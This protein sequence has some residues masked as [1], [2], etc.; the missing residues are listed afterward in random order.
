MLVSFPVPQAVL[1][2]AQAV[3]AAGGQAICVGGSVRDFF[4][5]IPPK[6]FD[7]ECHRLPVQHLLQVLASLNPERLDVVGVSFGVVKITLHGLELD[8]SV[9]RKDNK[10]GQGHTGFQVETDPGMGF[11]AACQRRDLTINAIGI[12]PLTGEVLDPCKGLVHLEQ[13]LLCMVNPQTF[14]E[15]PLRALRVMQLVARLG[16]GVEVRTRIAIEQMELSGLPAERLQEEIKKL[17]L[18]GKSFVL[19]AQLEASSKILQRSC[20]ITRFALQGHRLSQLKNQCQTQGCSETEMLVVMLAELMVGSPELLDTLKIHSLNGSN[21][22]GMIQ[23]LVQNRFCAI[24]ATA[25]CRAAETTNMKLLAILQQRPKLAEMAEALNCLETPLPVL[26]QG[27]DLLADPGIRQE[28]KPGQWI[29]EALT[30]VR[31]AQLQGFVT[32]REQA[33]NFLQEPA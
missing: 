23:A 32:T 30:K 19:A 29:G 31:E 17:L 4:L 22:R 5:G 15:D 10:V 3:Q 8:V 27:R 18:K 21:T 7:L 25:V 11:E 14:G 33:L 16:F 1:T 20:G 9:P 13:K 12:D 24:E 26:V 2:V 6:D 28:R